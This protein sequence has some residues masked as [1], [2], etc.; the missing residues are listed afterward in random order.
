MVKH[1]RF[2]PKLPFQT[3]SKINNIRSIVIILIIAAVGTV[4]LLPGHAQ[5]PFASVNASNGTI[6]SPATK[7]ADSSTD[8]GYK[9]M[10]GSSGSTSHMTNC[11][12]SPGACGYPDPAYG[13]VG[14]STSQCASLP[15][16]QPDDLSSN[17]YYYKGTGNLIEVQG[18]NV[19]IQN[20]N[21]T[22]W[23]FIISGVTGT[24]FN[25]D[26]MSTP[27]NDGNGVSITDG[28]NGK[29]YG[30]H[31]TVE[32]STISV[33][34][35]DVSAAANTACSNNNVEASNLGGS[36]DT[37]IKN[38]ILLGAIENINGLGT[39]SVVENNYIV[40]SSYGPDPHSEDI[41]GGV[42]TNNV[43]IS[44][45]TLFNPFYQTAEVFID[46]GGGTCQSDG[47][48]VTNNLMV[49]GGYVIYAC[50]GASGLGSNSFTFQNNDIGRC[51]GTPTYDPNV[52]G[53]Q[54]GPT[55]V[56]S[57]G[58]AFAAGADSH[59]F[60]PGGGYYGL[61][62]NVFCSASGTTWSDNYWDDNGA[63]IGC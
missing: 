9:V 49:G 45:N 38:N 40:A 12:I 11:F 17:D 2:F 23:T 37:I 25:N 3:N 39:G 27:G 62:Q 60:W 46:N 57:Y 34:G 14:L 18:T 13:N 61:T 15:A 26:C 44:H 52:G 22:G 41:Y 16:F 48:S 47:V 59:G 8:S 33:Q 20:Y 28:S 50:S 53:T 7:V 29:I 42:P 19:T 4:L 21:L 54:C 5:S 51:D 55:P 10:F 31:T 58:Q 56:S 32:N 24:V 36:D 30:S 1:N 6:S 35:C 63:A 43:T